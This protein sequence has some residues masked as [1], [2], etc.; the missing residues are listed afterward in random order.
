[1]ARYLRATARSAS[2][3]GLQPLS[4]QEVAELLTSRLYS[5]IVSGEKFFSAVI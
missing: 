2:A 1:M 5:P 3:P 4:L